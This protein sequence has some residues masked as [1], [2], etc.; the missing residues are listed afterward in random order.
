MGIQV[1]WERTRARQTLRVL[2]FSGAI[3]IGYY[4][5][6]GVQ[7]FYWGKKM[8][9]KT[10]PSSAKGYSGRLKTLLTV[11]PASTKQNDKSFRFIAKGMFSHIV[12]Q[13]LRVKM[14]FRKHTTY[15]LTG[16]SNMHKEKRSLYRESS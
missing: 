4:Q 11:P 1:V 3:S 16:S 15:P 9:P 2:V 12:I 13:D 10:K 7:T 8:W 6:A 5:K 14:S